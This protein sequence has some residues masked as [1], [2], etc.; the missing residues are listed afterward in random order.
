MVEGLS[1]QL[2]EADAILTRAEQAGMEIGSPRFELIAAK[3]SL[4][5]ARADTHSLDIEKV[6]TATESGLVVTQKSLKSGQDLLAE[7]QFRRKG[8]AASLL[9]IGAVLAGLFF[10]IR[11]VDRRKR[12]G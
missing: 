6:K 8:L 10:K 5:K 11:E 7:L 4:I 2:N 3:E 1:S 9:V 12:S